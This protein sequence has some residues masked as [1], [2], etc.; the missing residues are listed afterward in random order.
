MKL[1][2]GIQPYP[3]VSKCP[4]V[5]SDVSSRHLKRLALY[6][7]R[8]EEA[9]NEKFQWLWKGNWQGMFQKTRQ[10]LPRHWWMSARCPELKYRNI[11]LPGRYTGMVSEVAGPGRR[12]CYR[13]DT[14]KLAYNM[15]ETT[16][17]SLQHIGSELLSLMKPSWNSSA[18]GM[19][20]LSGERKV[21]PT[22][23]RILS[24]PW[25]MEVAALCSGA[26]LAHLALAT[27]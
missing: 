8:L 24:L 27:L 18:T 4:E 11:Q 16:Y 14:S 2:K 19:L 15:P 22:N 10:Q 23:H 5:E 9:E 21:K 12:L 7:I 17:R 25:S 6:K 3:S 1:E 26:A 13:S 20:P